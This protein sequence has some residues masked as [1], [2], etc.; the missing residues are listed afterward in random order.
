MNIV[1]F[2]SGYFLVCGLYV[3]LRNHRVRQWPYATGSMLKKHI[4]TGYKDID[5]LT[6]YDHTFDPQITAYV[7][8]EYSVGSRTYTG[9]RLSY[10][11]MSGNPIV[12]KLLLKQFSQIEYFP[13]GD[14]KVFYKPENPVRSVLIKPGWFSDCMGYVCVI[15]GLLFT[16]LE[17]IVF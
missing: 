2:I 10:T 13:N 5:D 7:K 11:L 16:Q 8:Y 1:P 3:L 4:G 15:L 17:P 6:A 12:H 9:D 14:L